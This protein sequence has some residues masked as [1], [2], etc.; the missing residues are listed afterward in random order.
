MYNHVPYSKMFEVLLVKIF[1]IPPSEKYF[2]KV[3]MAQTHRVARCIPGWRIM[4]LYRWGR[5]S[6]VI[7]R[8]TWLWIEWPWITVGNVLVECHAPCTPKTSFVDFE[9][10]T[11]NISSL[12]NSPYFFRRSQ[13]SLTGLIH[14]FPHFYIVFICCWTCSIPVHSWYTAHWNQAI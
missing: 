6:R 4:E 8:N 13:Q 9:T 14:P 11:L 1:F 2:K 3:P 5:D 12:L 7:I 10:N